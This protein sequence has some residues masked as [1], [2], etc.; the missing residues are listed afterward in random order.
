MGLITPSA[1]SAYKLPLPPAQIPSPVS[2]LST[3]AALTV[4]RG[5]VLREQH[6][7]DMCGGWEGQGC[8]K[9]WEIEAEWL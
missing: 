7:S 5:A 2:W 9:R 3:P 6:R 4:V 8:K 1:V